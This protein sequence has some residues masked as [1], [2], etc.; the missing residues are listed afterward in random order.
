M[1]S[2]RFQVSVFF[3]RLIFLFLIYIRFLFEEIKDIRI[4]IPSHLDDIAILAK[5][6]SLEN[7]YQILENIAKK[8]IYWG[9]NNRIEFDRDKTELIYF[10]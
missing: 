9:Q 1:F 8:L 4:R 5:S 3:A 2:V 6:E 7:N 10:Y